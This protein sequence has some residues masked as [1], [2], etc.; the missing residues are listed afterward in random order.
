MSDEII[1]RDHTMEDAKKGDIVRFIQKCYFGVGWRKKN[2]EDIGQGQAE[3]ERSRKI[4]ETL[5][6]KPNIKNLVAEKDGQIT[7]D[8]TGYLVKNILYDPEAKEVSLLIWC[9]DPE[10]NTKEIAKEMLNQMIAWGKIM[11]AT[12]IRMG[13][14]VNWPRSSHLAQTLI[15]RYGFQPS[16][17]VYIKP[18]K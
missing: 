5:I 18:I 12:V 3:V 17:M 15:D 1:I 9:E 7:C 8:M 13:F 2:L 6:N 4:H 14:N 11:G 10:L 16:E